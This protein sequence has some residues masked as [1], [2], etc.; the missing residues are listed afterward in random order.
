MDAMRSG[1]ATFSAKMA[2][3]PAA[4][5][6]STE[7]TDGTR[8]G[9]AGLCRERAECGAE[10]LEAV[11]GGEVTEGVMGGDELA[12]LLWQSSDLLADPPRIQGLQAR[13]GR[14]R[15]RLVE[16]SIRGISADERITDVLNHDDGVG[17]VVPHMGIDP[18]MSARSR[19]FHW[20][21]LCAA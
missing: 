19:P 18:P 17:D 5:I 7:Q 9:I 11:S 2:G 21:R 3:T 10:D 4:V 12:A 16:G 6:S 14:S 8:R 1:L 15:V 13:N 20:R